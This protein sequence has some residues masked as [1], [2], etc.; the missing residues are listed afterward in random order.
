MYNIHDLLKQSQNAEPFSKAQL[1]WMLSL[2]LDSPETYLLMAEAKRISKELTGNKAEVHGQFALNLAP[3][4]ENCKYC[5]FAA[6]N[7]VFTKAT[8]LSPEEAVESALYLEA[9]GAS[10]V[11]M[12][13]TANYLFGELLEMAQEVR[14]HI[15]PE[16]LLI[17]NVGD[18]TQK[19]ANEMRA[20][21]FDGVYHAMRLR[22]GVDTEIPPHKRMESFAAF[23]QAGLSI[24]TCVEPVGPEHRNDEIADMILLTAS[25]EPAYSG[26]ARRI[27]IPGTEMAEKY[28]M[29]SE[30]R[31][32]QCVAVT[33][34][35]MPRSVKGN[36]THEPCV[37]GAA[38]GAN[39]FWA[40]IGANPRDI[41]EKTEDGRG[42]TVQKCRALFEEADCGILDGQSEFY[43]TNLACI[44]QD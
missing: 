7:Q 8:K 40:E 32:A 41:K 4:G 23:R 44:H 38:A 18:R 35:G 26:A 43:K 30:I 34:L 42:F 25:L 31:Q 12:M 13:A 15:K 6:I 1:V 2:P 9:V 5:S 14:R 33:R 16:T 27:S 37:I 29:I 39:L 11:Y 28:G 21:G 22:E 3:C 36:C 19:E 10:A 24:G 20:A 17:A